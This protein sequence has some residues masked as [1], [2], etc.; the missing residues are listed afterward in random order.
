MF[1][2]LLSDAK[3]IIPSSKND[4]GEERENEQNEGPEETL[5]ET[6]ADAMELKTQV[7]ESAVSKEEETRNKI[8]KQ[9]LK[10]LKEHEVN[11]ISS[12][13]LISSFP[14][15]FFFQM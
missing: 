2:S 5:N 3:K 9:Y 4:D 15:Y 1:S 8:E 14:S 13:F 10:E 6:L 7:D 11:F 12:F